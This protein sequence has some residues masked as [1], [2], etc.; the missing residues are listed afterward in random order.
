MKHKKEYPRTLQIMPA[1]P[2]SYA[3]F[4]GADPDFD[5]GFALKVE[6]T[7]LVE[8]I[9]YELEDESIFTAVVPMVMIDGEYEEPSGN[10][11][12]LGIYEFKRPPTEKQ[13]QKIVDSHNTAQSMLDRSKRARAGIA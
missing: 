10:P 2:D 6:V 3:V 12:F 11:Q 13:I 5:S 1:A 8:K 4:S 9:S 7:A